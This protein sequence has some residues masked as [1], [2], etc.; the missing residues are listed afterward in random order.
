MI[1]RHGGYTDVELSRFAREGAVATGQSNCVG[2]GDYLA[3]SVAKALS[4]HEEAPRWHGREKVVGGWRRPM[5][6]GGSKS[7]V[8]G[9]SRA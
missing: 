6:H 9:A 1:A 7:Q 2:A 3:T 8:P 4:A 5:S